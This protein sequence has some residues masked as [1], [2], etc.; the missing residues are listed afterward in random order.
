MP[1]GSRNWPLP[2]PGEPNF[3]RKVP[4][5]E[6]SCT[7]SER[8]LTYTSPDELTA[9]PPIPLNWPS[10]VP[11]DPN[12]RTYSRL[13][14]NSSTRLWPESATQMLPLGSSAT[15]FGSLKLPS[16]LVGVK[17]VANVGGSPASH[18]CTRL[19]ALSAR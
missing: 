1:V 4:E 17:L 12:W 10:P 16:M 8:S 18:S 6:N 14:L 5:G 19:L 2:D 15:A 3:L 9:M 7:R 13:E 11:S